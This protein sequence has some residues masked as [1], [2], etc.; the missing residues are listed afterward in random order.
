MKHLV[1]GII[2][3]LLSGS[4]GVA[5][6]TGDLLGVSVAADSVEY[7][8][9]REE[10]STFWNE[11]VKFM[12][13]D[14]LDLLVPVDDVDMYNWSLFITKLREDGI[15]DNGIAG[16]LGNIKANGSVSPY[17]I[18]GYPYYR[19][20]DVGLLKPQ[21]YL[22][23]DGNIHAGEG[24]GICSWVGEKAEEL[25]ELSELSGVKTTHWF[26]DGST[27]FTQHTCHLPDMESQIEFLLKDLNGDYIDV[28][29]KLSEA[30]SPSEA[31]E[32]YIQGY[33][34]FY[35][36]WSESCNEAA[37]SCLPLVEACRGII[38]GR[39]D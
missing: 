6:E 32:A 8:P 11:L 23:Y 13:H 17:C 31:V 26:A 9:S 35:R 16:I 18:S 1:V 2:L 20:G 5:E 30:S 19:G 21:G 27:E 34:Q 33:V 3:A 28:K 39:A 14:Y 12:T 22:D 24:H 38:E 10:V 25:S 7:H 4:F 15:S 29:E 37:E 36:P